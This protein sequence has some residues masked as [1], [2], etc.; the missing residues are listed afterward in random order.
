[1]KIEEQI[2]R[3]VR[4]TRLARSLSQ[5]ELAKLAGIEPS[6]LSE[7]ER[8]KADPDALLMFKLARVMN[9]PIADLFAGV[10]MPEPKTPP[11]KRGIRRRKPGSK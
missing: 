6:Y 4:R 7:I 10:T 1:V 11:P 8:G 5:D 9:V 2:G 3:A